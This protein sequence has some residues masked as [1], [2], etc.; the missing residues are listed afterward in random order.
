MDDTMSAFLAGKMDNGNGGGCCMPMVPMYGA[1]PWGMGGTMGGYGM[2]GMWGDW[3]PL[4]IILAL[5]G[6]GIGGFGFGGGGAGLQGIATRADINEGFA[7]NNITGG[8]T[9]IQQGICDSTYAIN[10]AI[11][12]VQGA[13]CQGFN[14]INTTMLQGFNGVERG[15]CDL[16]HQ[17]SDCCCTT[18]RA[19]DGVNFN[20]AKGL[21]DIGN[22]INVQTRDIVDNA[23][24]NYRGLMDFLVGEKLASKDATI[25]ELRN[26]VSQ[27]NQTSVIGARIDAAVAE[28]LRRTGNDCP[29]AAYLVQPPTPVNFPTN[30][31]GQVQ[32]GGNNW[33]C[34][35]AA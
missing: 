16:S 31:C 35:C 22:L 19:I 13:L 15:F 24:A 21:C 27:A 18:Q 1:M 3:I 7:L 14:G 11:N 9:A 10:N 6:G 26:Q 17:L 23:N 2:G 33:G 8:I 34:G 4:I 20:L 25:A 5:L 30:G 29:T 32:F 28:L 12:G